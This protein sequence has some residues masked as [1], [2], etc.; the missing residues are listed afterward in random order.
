M[1]LI[2]HYLFLI[3]TSV[4]RTAPKQKQKTKKTKT[5]HFR[6]LARRLHEDRESSNLTNCVT[7]YLHSQPCFFAAHFA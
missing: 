5:V 3:E 7:F 4:L 6:I 1:L 2:N